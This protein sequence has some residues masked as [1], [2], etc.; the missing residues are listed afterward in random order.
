MSVSVL[1]Q[2]IKRIREQK[3][4]TAA[5]LAKKANIGSA[6]I[7][8]IESG[9][10]QS[11]QSRTIEKIALALEITT[12]YLFEFEIHEEYVVEDIRDAIKIVL[13]S[14]EITLDGVELTYSEKL[15]IFNNLELSLQLIRNNRNRVSTNEHSLA[16]E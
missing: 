10:R 8:E 4:M 11:L 12:D 13:E 1:G 6:T 2:N 16:G 15:T 7:S 5:T 3:N 9:V 14:D